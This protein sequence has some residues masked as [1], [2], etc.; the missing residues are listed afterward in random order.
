M[1]ILVKKIYQNKFI[2]FENR[3]KNRPVR[4]IIF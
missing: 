4:T 3:T 1:Q 2:A